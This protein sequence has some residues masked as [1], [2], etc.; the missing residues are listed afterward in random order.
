MVAELE[1]PEQYTCSA[2]FIP[3]R[4]G[5]KGIAT[6]NI[7]EGIRMGVK[8]TLFFIFIAAVLLAA[9]LARSSDL[10]LTSYDGGFFTIQIPY[11]WKIYTA[12]QCAQLAFVVRDKQDQLRQIFFFGSVGPVY[13]SQQQKQ[14]DWNYANMGGYP[15]TWI[16]MPVISP[17][18]PQNFMRHFSDIASTR[19]AQEFMPQVPR[20]DNLSVICVTEQPSMIYGGKTAL[21]RALFTKNQKVGEGLFLCTVAPFLPFTGAPGG[22][23]AY[24]FMVSGITATKRE[25]PI[26]LRILARS[27]ASFNVNPTYVNQCINASQ[28]A[29][30]Q[31]VKAGQTLREVSDLIIKGWEDRNKRYDIIA[32]KR[33]DSILGFKRVYDPDTKETYQVDPEFWHQYK[34]NRGRFRMNNLRVIPN[35]NYELWNRAP[36]PQREIK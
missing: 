21:I 3:V 32:E 23:N 6:Q 9:P 22:G 7:E 17:L 35:N 25:F 12:G 14:I 8:R 24:G 13:M 33:S 26:V 18:T 30:R 29:F 34:L 31:I 19:I 36:R 28:A 10:Q 27:M 16:D 20:L 4:S 2:W 15:V 5:A 1:G 11:G